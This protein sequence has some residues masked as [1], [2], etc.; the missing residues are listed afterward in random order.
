M[1]AAIAHAALKSRPRKLRLGYHK[2]FEEPA[3]RIDPQEEGI[4]SQ[5]VKKDNAKIET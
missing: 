4:I 2:Y 3:V 5:P 1:M